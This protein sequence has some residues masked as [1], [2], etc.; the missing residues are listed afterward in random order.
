MQHVAFVF[1][2]YACRPEESPPV[3]QQATFTSQATAQHHVSTL[4][5]PLVTPTL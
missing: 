5:L 2:L 3:G 1:C 4:T